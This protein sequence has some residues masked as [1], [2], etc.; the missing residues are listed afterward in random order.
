MAQFGSPGS[1]AAWH[2][3]LSSLWPARCSAEGPLVFRSMPM[4]IGSADLQG[5]PVGSVVLRSRRAG[6]GAACGD[7]DPVGH[8]E[9][10]CLDHG[11]DRWLDRP[12]RSCS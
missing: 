3:C 1:Y 8:D 10:R 11:E 9:D 12:M 2:G 5:T 7:L 6:G 4:G